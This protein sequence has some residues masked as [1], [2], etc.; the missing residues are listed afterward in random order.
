METPVATS[1]RLFGSVERVTFHNEENG[2]CVLRVK[3]Q[4]KKEPITLIGYSNAI[5]PGENLEAQ[6]TWT[7]HREFGL[8]FKADSIQ[9]AHPSTLEGIE[10]Y[11][12]SGMVRGIGPH[13]AKKMVE[14][15]G[16]Q[17]FEVI[18]NEPEKLRRVPG[19]GSGRLSKIVDAWKE[20]KAVR[21]IMVFLSHTESGPGVRFAFTRPTEAPPSSV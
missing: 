19:I 15:F 11:L 7:N 1:E 5:S 17:V 14:T 13:F 16:K 9:T 18:E 10:R 21:E 2:Y 8:Q 20:Q 4:G 6:G 3:A 12:G